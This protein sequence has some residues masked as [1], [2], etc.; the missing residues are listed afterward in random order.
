MGY[1]D[2]S[3]PASAKQVAASSADGAELVSNPEYERWYNQEQQVLT[4]LLSSIGEEVLQDVVPATTSKQAWDILQKQFSSATRAR[5]VQVRVE[6]A[7]LKKRDQSAADY[8]HKIK[9]YAMELSLV[10][11]PLQ[12]DEVIAYL[13]NG[14]GPEYDSFVTSMTTKDS[15]TLDDVCSHL[16]TFEARQLQHQAEL[17]LQGNMSANY[18]NR[19]PP[20]QN[21]QW[22]QKQQ[23]Q[24]WQQHQQQYRSRGPTR[25]RGPQ[26]FNGGQ[27][28]KPRCQICTRLGH[29]AV[30]C[31]YRLVKVTHLLKL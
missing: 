18:T 21:Q 16:M 23:G 4:G 26:Q 11:A 17:Q 9:G 30:K 24:Q 28:S 12:D 10:G 7:T 14:L 20:Q 8:F 15:L 6:L 5:S 19:G 2:G 13:L 25:G 3:L 22:H 31:W 27:T 29:T 1:L